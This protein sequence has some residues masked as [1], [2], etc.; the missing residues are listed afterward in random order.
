MPNKT[1]YTLK[2]H[3]AMRTLPRLEHKGV[4]DD[5]TRCEIAKTQ[6]DLGNAYGALGHPKK[7]IE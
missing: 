1:F 6:A 5:A 4:H 7:Q 2:K 3:M